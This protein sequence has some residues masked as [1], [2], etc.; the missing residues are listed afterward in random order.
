MPREFQALGSS[1][2]RLKFMAVWSQAGYILSLLISKLGTITVMT[3][4]DGDAD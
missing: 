4:C 3:S 1:G 2:P